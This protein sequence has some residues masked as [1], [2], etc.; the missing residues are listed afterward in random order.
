MNAGCHQSCR[1][2]VEHCPL[3]LSAPVANARDPGCKPGVGKPPRN[4]LRNDP[5][6][7]GIAGAG[8]AMLN[9]RHPAERIQNDLPAE[10]QGVGAR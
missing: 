9:E 7:F 2:C 5:Y 3:L 4:N 6:T 8:E 10:L 1:D